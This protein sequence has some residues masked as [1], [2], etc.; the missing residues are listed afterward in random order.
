MAVQYPRSA[1]LI[2]LKDA[3]K[4]IELHNPTI[5]AVEACRLAYRKWENASEAV[6]AKYMKMSRQ[7]YD[8]AWSPLASDLFDVYVEHYLPRF[9]LTD[10]HL[11]KLVAE[12]DRCV[13]AGL[14]RL[15]RNMVPP[16]RAED[17]F[18]LPDEHRSAA[19]SLR[20][21]YLLGGDQ[22]LQEDLIRLGA[23]DGPLGFIR[24]A[25]LATEVSRLR[26]IIKR[27]RHAILGATAKERMEAG[28]KKKRRRA[29]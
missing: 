18:D 19:L 29:N 21:R 6:K 25:G 15:N 9:R 10:S 26:A 14:D 5:T 11:K 7:E 3:R 22:F 24:E 13:E 1:C 17:Y 12:Y 28:G 27:Q 16:Y 20:N 4:S 23:S 8:R 2:F